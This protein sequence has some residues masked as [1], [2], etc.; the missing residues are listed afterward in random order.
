MIGGRLLRG[1]IFGLVPGLIFGLILGWFRPTAAGG[2]KI[3]SLWRTGTS[4]LMGVSHR[5]IFGTVLRATGGAGRRGS[6][7][8]N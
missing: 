5:L 7:S 2:R 3:S 4:G 8:P 1:L 6:F